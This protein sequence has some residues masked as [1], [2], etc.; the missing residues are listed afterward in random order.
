M[1]AEDSPPAPARPW[2]ASFT[3]RLSFLFGILIAI[4]A[5]IGVRVW[6]TSD[7]FVVDNDWVE[8]TLKVENQ[9][10]MVL[11]RL[12]SS[13]AAAVAYAV[14]GA[15]AR[16]IEFNQEAPKLD[17]DL[18]VLANL[19]ADNPEQGVH[20]HQLAA[21][22]LARRDLL[23]NAVALRQQSHAL[24][25]LPE[26]GTDD[27][28]A[29]VAAT[30][31][32]EDKLLVLRHAEA[33][34]TISLTRSLTTAAVL[35]SA[36]FLAFTFWLTRRNY[37]YQKRN[38]QKLTD[39]HRQAHDAL[40]ETRR[41]SDSM[42][43][44]AQFGELLQSC[45]TMD[46]VRDGVP[47][48]LGGLLPEVAGRLALLNASQNLLAIGAHWGQHGIIAESVFAPEDCWALRRG[49]TYPLAGADG[50]FVC[51]HVHWPNP[52]MPDARYLCVPLAAQGEMIGVVTFDAVRPLD[53]TERRLATAASEQLALA[54]ANLRLQD[55]LRT[56]SI[57]DPLTG[58]FNRRYLEVSLERELVRAGRRSLPLAVLMLDLDH[59]K[60][61]ND[62]Y[63]HD[64]G[65]ALL[66]QFAEVLKRCTR[67]EDIACRYGG[68]EFT[69]ILLESDVETAC[70][71]AEQ[72]R[73][74]TAEMAVEHRKQKL[75]RVSV[76]IGVAMFPADGQVSAD[77]QRRA[78]S[79]LY[80]AKKT[81][82]DRVVTADATVIDY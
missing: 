47:I 5:L 65:D 9:A 37:A 2:F 22:V 57:R 28:R 43:R 21:L 58:L 56:Q 45:R 4:L 61:F 75:G 40:L 77:L 70:K 6:Q 73:A 79:A 33:A 76:S 35:T 50:A 31:A 13:Q 81:G 72:I 74:A 19:V 46:E 11:A 51:K 14:S 39:S 17:E 15:P 82:R 16:L 7:H 48:A 41:L 42:Q 52:D 24:P 63:G 10:Q 60:R 8:H 18:R 67:S 80:Q 55:T 29:V 68:E 26:I 1:T 34:H 44:L 25:P 53:A 20:A 32:A 3:V 23:A 59:F 66:V 64:A 27:I 12:G 36:I 71:R 38:Q 54:L 69:V 78:D 62:T 30:L 49:Q